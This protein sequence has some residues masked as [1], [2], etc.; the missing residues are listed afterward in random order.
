MLK[1]RVRLFCLEADSIKP[2]TPKGEQE[3]IKKRI[4][5]SIN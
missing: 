5:K 2:L 3:V 1:K 4:D